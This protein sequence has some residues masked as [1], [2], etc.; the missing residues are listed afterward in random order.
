MRSPAENAVIY[1][2]GNLYDAAKA[3][4]AAMAAWPTLRGHLAEA[5]DSI[6][7]AQGHVEECKLFAREEAKT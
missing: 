4:E 2:Y 1:L 3:C 7:A 6:H 5:L